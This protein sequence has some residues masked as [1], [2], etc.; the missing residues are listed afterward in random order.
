MRLFLASV[1]VAVSLLF[2]PGCG[3]VLSTPSTNYPTIYAFSAPGC[4][5]C[6]RDKSRLNQLERAGY[7]VRRVDITIRGKWQRK[8]RVKAVPLYLVIDRGKIVLRTHDL[9]LAIRTI[10]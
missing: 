5:G 4:V 8:Y 9:N 6:A 7:L 2:L 10:R 1:C 3:E